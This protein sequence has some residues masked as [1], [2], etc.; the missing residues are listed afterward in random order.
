MYVKRL[1]VLNEL[2]RFKIPCRSRF[3]IVLGGGG[4]GGVWLLNFFLHFFL[5]A[6]M[7][8]YNIKIVI[9]KYEANRRKTN[10]V[11]EFLV[12]SAPLRFEL[13]RGICVRPATWQLLRALL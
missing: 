13:R 3:W 8:V 12:T 5:F 2:N 4:G 6:Y 11:I 10:G 9:S 7:N 1:L